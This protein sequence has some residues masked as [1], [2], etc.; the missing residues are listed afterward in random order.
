MI[1]AIGVMFVTGLLLVA[2]FTVANGDVHNSR[3]D[4]VREAGLLR[5]AGRRAAVRVRLQADPNFWQNC[6]NVESQVPAEKEESYIVKPVPAT[7]QAACSDIEPLHV[8]DRV[9]RDLREHVPDPLDGLRRR[10]GQGR[11][12]VADRRSRRSRST[13]SS[14]T[15]TSPTTNRP[16]RRC[17]RNPAAP[18]HAKAAKAATTANSPKNAKKSTTRSGRKKASAA[19]RS[20]S[21]KAISSKGRS[22]PTMPPRSSAPPRS[23]AKATCRSTSSK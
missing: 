5:R 20:T 14:T 9:Q 1:I 23:G 18:G 12:R 17:T 6:K 22:I 19:S 4:A 11:L 15:S 21:A 10:Q 2:A 13:A 8:D 7:G 16:I 3:R